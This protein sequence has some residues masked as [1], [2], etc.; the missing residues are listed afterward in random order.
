M[1][2]GAVT[3]LPVERSVVHATRDGVGLWCWCACAPH[4]LLIRDDG[5]VRAV[6]TNAEPVDLDRLRERLPH[7]DAL[8]ATL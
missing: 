1:R 5:G 3:L 2:F 4:A 8:L 7:L 6:D